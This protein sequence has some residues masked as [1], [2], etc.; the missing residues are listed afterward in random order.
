MRPV[1]RLCS[2]S[3]TPVVKDLPVRATGAALASKFRK[4]SVVA[5]EAEEPHFDFETYVQCVNELLKLSENQ[6]RVHH[7]LSSNS[8]N[9]EY[10]DY[11]SVLD[12]L[13]KC[14]DNQVRVAK[15]F[16]EPSRRPTCASL[17][18]ADTSNDSA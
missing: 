8:G 15:F 3:T 11:Q 14:K 7:L 4:L 17:F 12:T 16:S 2:S 5:K 1:M 6:S 13:L 18:M 9:P 10:I